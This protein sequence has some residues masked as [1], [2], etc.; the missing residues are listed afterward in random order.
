MHDVLNNVDVDKSHH[1]QTKT[2]DLLSAPGGSIDA[3]GALN[4]TSG[5]TS[6]NNIRNTSTVF[7]PDINL[8]NMKKTRKILQLYKKIKKSKNPRHVRKEAIMERNASRD[9]YL[10]V[11]SRSHA[12]GVSSKVVGC[13]ELASSD[14]R[15]VCI[16]DS[17]TQ[18]MLEKEAK[19]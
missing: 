19:K 17:N 4:A 14:R 9:E 13:Q 10:K 15:F 7:A 12:A 3:S 18:K 1:L 6:R 2:I 5:P 16:D 11:E 8:D